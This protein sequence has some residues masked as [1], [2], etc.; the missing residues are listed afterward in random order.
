MLASSVCASRQELIGAL[1]EHLTKP[2]MMVAPPSWQ[3]TLAS[4]KQLG[5]SRLYERIKQP[6]EP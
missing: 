3:G 6:E 5:G 2:V 1:R 4:S